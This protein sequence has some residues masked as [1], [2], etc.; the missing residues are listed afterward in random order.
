MFRRYTH[1]ITSTMIYIISVSFSPSFHSYICRD[2]SV[3]R[4][5]W[6]QWPEHTPGNAWLMR[7]SRVHTWL[8]GSSEGDA[9]LFCGQSAGKLSPLRWHRNSRA[10]FAGGHGPWPTHPSWL[11]VGQESGMQCTYCATLAKWFKHESNMIQTWS[12]RCYSEKSNTFSGFYVTPIA[13]GASGQS[14][15]WCHAPCPVEAPTQREGLDY[16]VF[17]VSENQQRDHQRFHRLFRSLNN[18]I[19]SDRRI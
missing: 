12:H 1:V 4:L 9:V 8:W 16:S 14:A 17:E 11:R 2:L 18:P 7:G 5:K 13:S 6:L 19:E 10:H 15:R 3:K